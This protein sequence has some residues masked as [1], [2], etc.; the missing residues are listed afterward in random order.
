MAPAARLPAPSDNLAQ[1][2]EGPRE[3]W[4]LHKSAWRSGQRMY[5]CVRGVV[6]VRVGFL[7]LSA[8]R[9]R[10]GLIYPAA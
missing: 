1:S 4:L 7:T 2:R 3:S 9:A 6:S 8:L 10:G 5:A